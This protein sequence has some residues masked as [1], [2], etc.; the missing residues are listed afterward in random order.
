MTSI[1]RCLLPNLLK[2]RAAGWLGEVASG[3]LRK[4]GHSKGGI[5]KGI[6]A[7]GVAC[8]KSQGR[9]DGRVRWGEHEK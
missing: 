4:R 3:V 6:R 1:P 9:G 2:P 5:W 8:A 7:K